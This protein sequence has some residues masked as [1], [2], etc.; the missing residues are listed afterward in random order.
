[1]EFNDQQVHHWDYSKHVKSCYG[2]KAEKGQN[3]ED[4]GT[5]AYLLFYERVKKKPLKLKL[6]QDIKDKDREASEIASKT[7]KLDKEWRDFVDEDDKNNNAEILKNLQVN[8]ANNQEQ[9][10]Y[11]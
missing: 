2:T 6:T 3:N 1:M 5:S 11:V 9:E 8:E 4:Y 7:V 10:D